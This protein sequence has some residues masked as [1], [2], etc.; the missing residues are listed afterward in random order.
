MAP[1]PV[2]RFHVRMSGKTRHHQDTLF[3]CHGDAQGQ[4]YF[5][6]YEGHGAKLTP[7]P[8]GQTGASTSFAT[9]HPSQR[10]IYGVHNRTDHLVALAVAAERTTPA[11]RILNRVA[12][13]PAEGAAQAGP[14]YI[15]T[16]PAG[17]FLLVANYRGHNVVV[18]AL[19]PDGRVGPLV[20]NVSDGK[21][22]HLVRLTPDGRFALVPYLGSDLIAQYRFDPVRGALARN[23]PPSVATP[24]GAGPRH[25][26]FHPQQKDG[27]RHVFVVNELDA[28][29]TAYALDVAAGTLSERCRVDT[30]PAGYAGQRWAA[31]VA[32]APSG[33]FVYVCNRAHDSLAVFAWDGDGQAALHLVQHLPCGGQTPRHFTLDRDGRFLLVA[34]QD[35]GNLAVFAVDPRSGRLAPHAL[36]PVGAQPCFVGLAP[37]TAAGGG[38]L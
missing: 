32:V 4:I 2:W 36:H 11:L 34:N 27:V 12:V 17:R 21:H 31:H 23:Q 35:S 15:T 8:A 22:A 26:D 13:P 28:T 16:D 25:L 7:R 5:Y 6:G 37:R 30:L 1:A 9:W 29:L 10:I 24:A 38:T 3:V 19:H 18:F 20:E 14:A 33:R